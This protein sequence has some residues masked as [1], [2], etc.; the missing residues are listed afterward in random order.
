MAI[1]AE[2]DH[3]TLR[4]ARTDTEEQTQEKRDALNEAL[5]ERVP[6]LNALLTEAYADED[7]GACVLVLPVAWR[8]GGRADVDLFADGTA[9]QDMMI[10]W[11]PVDAP[12]VARLVRQEESAPED[13]Q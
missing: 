9:F 5:E 2:F 6:A 12:Y 4:A 7:L 1:F 13:Q 3:Q 10:M 11:A 8:P